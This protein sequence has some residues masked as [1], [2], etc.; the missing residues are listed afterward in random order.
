MGYLIDPPRQVEGEY[1]A[2]FV[3]TGLA[4]VVAGPSLYGTEGLVCVPRAEAEETL[5]LLQFDS[6]ML[7]REDEET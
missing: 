3:Q 7:D 2:V 4:D 1:V 5:A 6:G